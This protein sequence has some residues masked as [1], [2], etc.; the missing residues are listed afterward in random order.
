MK[1][2]IIRTGGKQYLVEEGSTLTVETLAN[3]AG[4]PEVLLVGD[5]K[6]LT[7]GKPLVSGVSAQFSREGSLRERK[8]TTFKYKPKARTRVKKG[9]R[10]EKDKIRIT[11]IG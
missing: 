7:I 6:G 10:Q 1:F 11:S 4:I 2:A 5:D 3:D 8:V 9:S